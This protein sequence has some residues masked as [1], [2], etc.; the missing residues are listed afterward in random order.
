M[1]KKGKLTYAE[2]R[3]VLNSLP[4]ERLGEE[5]CMWHPYFQRCFAVEAIDELSSVVPGSDPR[6]VLITSMTP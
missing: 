5:L 3:D 6:I 2:L 4:A 1:S